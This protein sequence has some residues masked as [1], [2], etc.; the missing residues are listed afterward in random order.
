[1]I[2]AIAAVLAA[3]FVAEPAATARLEAATK[4]AVAAET[5]ELAQSSYSL[6]EAAVQAVKYASLV[7]P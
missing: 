5:V 7:V 1:M 3:L 6:P 2:A 4:A